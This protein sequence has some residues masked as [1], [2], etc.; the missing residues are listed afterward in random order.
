MPDIEVDI[1]QSEPSQREHGV[2]VMDTSHLSSA[3]EGLPGGGGAGGGDGGTT[4]T[5]SGKTRR[6][7]RRSGFHIK[8]PTKMG[9][10]MVGMILR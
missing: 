4:P 8:V 2:T 10:K 6:G 9:R 5:S 3:S 1:L 7:S